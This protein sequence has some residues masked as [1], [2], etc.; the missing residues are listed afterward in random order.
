MAAKRRFDDGVRAE[1]GEQVDQEVT[2]SHD[3]R[4]TRNDGVESGEDDLRMTTRGDEFPIIR[5]IRLASAHAIH[6][7]AH[8]G[9]VYSHTRRCPFGRAVPSGG[10][11]GAP[12]DH[13]SRRSER[14]IL[15]AEAVIPARRECSGFGRATLAS[16]PRIDAT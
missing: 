10:R 7:V 2:S 15:L 11:G 16:L 8:G 3:P 12:R 5:P 14:G 9:S 1:L 13:C 4:H 6:L